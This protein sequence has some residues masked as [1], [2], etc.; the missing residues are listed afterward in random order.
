M[1]ADILL[2]GSHGQY[3]RNLDASDV[4]LVDMNINDNA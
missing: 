1:Q 3:H 4:Y 2:E